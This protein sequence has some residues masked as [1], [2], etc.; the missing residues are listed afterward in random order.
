[1]KDKLRKPYIIMLSAAMIFTLI[2]AFAACSNTKNNNSSPT[3][4]KP[5][6]KPG[7]NMVMTV[8]G[9]SELTGGENVE[10]TIQVTQ[11]SLEEGFIGIDFSLEYNTDFLEFVSSEYEKLPSESWEG[12]SRD[13]GDGLRLFNAFDDSDDEVTPVTG[14]DQFEVKV[15]FKVKENASSDKDTIVKLI[16]VT[17]AVNDSQISMGYGTGNEIKKA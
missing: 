13:D 14:A 12:Y 4:A 9:P 7:D 8:A 10:Y 17:G 16:N 6:T 11:C 3:D 5:T 2:M 1:M 15:T